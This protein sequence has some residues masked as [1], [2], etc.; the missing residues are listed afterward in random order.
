MMDIR[1]EGCRISIPHELTILTPEDENAD[2]HVQLDDGREYAGTLYTPA[3]ITSLLHKFERS[4]E[5]ALGRYFWDPT[6]LVVRDLT[7]ETIRAAIEDLVATGDIEKI[8]VR[9]E[10]LDE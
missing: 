7:E 10:P 9:S 2:V 8:F 6:M 1:G 4:G 5:C 3:N